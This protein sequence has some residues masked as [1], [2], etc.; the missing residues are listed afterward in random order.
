[1]WHNDL[2]KK[3]GIF[4]LPF[5]VRMKPVEIADYNWSKKQTKKG[6]AGYRCASG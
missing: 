2:L 1:V 5:V 6:D 3:S 4:S